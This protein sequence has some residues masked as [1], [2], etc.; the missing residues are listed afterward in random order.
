MRLKIALGAV[1]ALVLSVQFVP[2]TRTNPPAD[3][4]IATPDSVQAILSRACYDCHS[5]ET[6]WPWY[7][8]VAP[9]SW[10]IT[11]HVT[12]G[13]E[14]LNFSTWRQYDDEERAEKLDEIWEEVEEG[15]MPRSNYWRLHSESRLSDQDLA[16]LQQW[17][18]DALAMLE[19][20]VSDSTRT[21]LH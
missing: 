8:Y 13:R 3:G 20:E 10:R 15:K 21:E 9:V 7:A 19:Q 17:T 6:D 16:V 11:G 12:H 5:N 14:H 4:E 2:V 18:I 1:A